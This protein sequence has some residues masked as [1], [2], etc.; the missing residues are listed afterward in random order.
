MFWPRQGRA[1]ADTSV[2]AKAARAQTEVPEIQHPASDAVNQPVVAVHR[3]HT[4]ALKG[5]HVSDQAR[6]PL[7]WLD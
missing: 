3:T 5:R 1:Q 6:N 2:F 7:C 4:R